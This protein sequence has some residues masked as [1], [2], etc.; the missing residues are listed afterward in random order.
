MT[1]TCSA[2]AASIFSGAANGPRSA[3][4]NTDKETDV[5]IEIPQDEDPFFYVMGKIGS[6]KL[7]ESRINSWYAQY[8]NDSPLTP[9]E[10]EAMRTRAAHHVGCSSCVASRMARDM[11]G[12]SDEPI[13]EEVYDNVFAYK[14]W[15]GYTERERLIIEFTERYILDYEGLAEDH[16]F[17]TRLKAS[18]SDV[19][20][21]DMCLLLGMWDSSTRMYHLLVGIN[22]SCSLPT[23]TESATGDW[24]ELWREND[25]A[26]AEAAKKP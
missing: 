23:D 19:E 18:F 11:P 9:R 2:G 26:V 5:R 16:G 12:F 14:T 3:D 21:A 10:R 17:W 22:A 24:R 7:L 20:L 8:L 4:A 6:P 1:S 15:P 13:P 25:A